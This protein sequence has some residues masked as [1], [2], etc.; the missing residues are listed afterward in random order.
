MNFYVMLSKK[1]ELD[2]NNPIPVGPTVTNY[3]QGKKGYAF[4]LLV[5]TLIRETKVITIISSLPFF[6]L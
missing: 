1:C 3:F 4:W 6:I 5:Q 2:V